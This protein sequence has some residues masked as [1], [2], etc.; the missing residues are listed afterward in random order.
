MQQSQPAKNPQGRMRG[1]LGSGL[2]YGFVAFDAYSRMQEGENAAVATGKAVLSNAAWM[3]V[4]GGVPAMLGL[5]ALQMAPEISHAV[6]AA[7]AGVSQRKTMFGGGF[8]Q[9]QGQQYMQQMGLQSI[10]NARSN[11]SA[12]MAN[13]ARGARKTY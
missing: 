1:L 7:K 5:S 2:G 13:H 12:V 11:A 8:Q 6:D 10:M 3:M 9:T 4:P